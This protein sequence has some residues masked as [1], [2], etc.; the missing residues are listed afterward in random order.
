M[1]FSTGKNAGELNSE[2]N[3]TPMVDVMLVLLVAFIITI[4]A[5]QN[6]VKINIPKTAATAPLTEVKPVTVSVDADAK[7][8][9]NK[10]EISLDN[11]EVNLKARVAETPDL[12][13]NFQADENVPYR[14]IAKAL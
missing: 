1:G 6:A 11:L 5:V 12:P 8:Y 2:I 14:T 4:P 10:E 3:V 7:I 13:V 9:L